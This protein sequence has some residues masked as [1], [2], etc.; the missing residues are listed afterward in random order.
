MEER[1]RELM[2]QGLEEYPIRL[3]QMQMEQFYDYYQM[4]LQWNKV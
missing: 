2:E 3:S 1:F 4:L